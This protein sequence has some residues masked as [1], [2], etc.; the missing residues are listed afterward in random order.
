VAANTGAARTGTLTIAGQTFTVNQAAGS[1]T[2][3]IACGE[4]KSGALATSDPRSTVRGASYYA[5][6]YT[7]T[8]TGS[9]A[10]FTAS[11]TWDNYLILKASPTATTAI[12][13]NDDDPAGGTN[14]KLTVTTLTTGVTYYLE[15][16]SYSANAT[17][18][19]TATATC[20]GG[21]VTLVNEGAESGASGWTVT[22]NV[23]GNNWVVSTNGRRTGSNGFRTANNATYVDNLDQS[24]IS[25]AFS[26]AGRTSASLTYYFKHDTESSYDFFRVEISTNGGSTWT[27]LSSTSGLSSGFSATAGAGFAPQRTISLTPYVGQASVKIRFRFTSDVS[28]TDWGAAVDD[29]VV[30][31]Q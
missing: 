25:P 7:F 21:P 16:T 9:S 30:T 23:T 11:S 4:T 1:S 10:T 28:V 26:L 17:G 2:T 14:A 24:I 6:T 31:A 13:Q 18:S 12:A 22:T 3:S 19:Y 27:S 20:S 8:A 15:V 29:I 5:D